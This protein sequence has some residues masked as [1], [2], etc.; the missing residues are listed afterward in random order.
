M[1]Q[2]DDQHQP[3]QQPQSDLANELRELGHQIEQTIRSALESDRARQ[4]QSDIS[5]GLREI[6]AQLQNAMKA[7][8]ENPQVKE[9]VQRGEQAVSQA[10]QSKVAQD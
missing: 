1:S 6:G 8:Q 9:L 7:I 2:P 4:L 10:Q 3:P 5:A